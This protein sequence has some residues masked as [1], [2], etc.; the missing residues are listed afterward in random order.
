M[1]TPLR[2]GL[3]QYIER[4][5]NKASVMHVDVFGYDVGEGLVLIEYRLSKGGKHH[6]RNLYFVCTLGDYSEPKALRSDHILVV[7]SRLLGGI[8]FNAKIRV[9]RWGDWATSYHH[10][11]LRD[12]AN[13]I[14]LEAGTRRR[15]VKFHYWGCPDHNP[16][17]GFAN[18]WRPNRAKL[19]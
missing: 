8:L 2:P 1:S 14:P 10:M 13:A 6:I 9:A 11:H 7:D 17:D 15:S 16:A 12:L 19:A 3:S 5:T 4:I 18:W